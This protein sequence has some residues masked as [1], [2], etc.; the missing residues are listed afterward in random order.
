MSAYRTLHFFQFGLT[1]LLVIIHSLAAQDRV[2]QKA[3]T[4]EKEFKIK[5]DFG[6]GQ[7]TLK[8]SEDNSLYRLTTVKTKD[9]IEPK[10]R[11]EKSGT[12]AVLIISMEQNQSIN[13]FDVGDQ[14]WTLE[15]TPQIPVLL[16]ADLGACRGDLNFSELRMKDISMSTGASTVKVRFDQPNRERL[17]KF[18]IEAGISRLAFTGL[19]NANFDYLKFEGGVGSYRMDFSGNQYDNNR[20][21]ISV[22]VGKVLLE[23]PVD[24]VTKITP[25]DNFLSSVNIEEEY[26]DRLTDGIYFTKKGKGHNPDLSISIEAGLGRV[27]VK[28]IP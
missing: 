4:D 15:I 2:F 22:G 10:V 28:V 1:G 19:G 8:K 11:Y 3:L 13:I 17:R 23:L 26:F 9:D 16:K 7:I 14:N 25:E 12:T 6:A 18:S 24:V 21:D 5:M 20:V 27:D